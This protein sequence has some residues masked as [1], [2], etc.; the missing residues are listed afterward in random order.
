MDVLKASGIQNPIIRVGDGDEVLAY[1]K[2]EGLYGNRQSFPL[3]GLLLLDLKMPRV[4]GFQVLEWIQTQ[5]QLK[6]MLVVVLSGH[7]DLKDVKHAYTLGAHTFLVKPFK[8]ED[9]ANLAASFSSHLAGL[10]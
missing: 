5:P 4:D 8:L 2:G 3:P 1:L 6:N 10:S 9:M 7:N